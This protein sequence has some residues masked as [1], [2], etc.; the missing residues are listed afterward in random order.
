M[1]IVNPKVNTFDHEDNF[2]WNDFD[3]KYRDGIFNSYE[4]LLE[5]F[6]RDIVKVLRWISCG[7]GY[8]VKKTNL[9][10]LMFDCTDR[11]GI[12]VFPIR[13]REN[14]MKVVKGK[15]V[16]NEVELEI[17]SKKLIDIVKTEITSTEMVFRPSGNCDKTQFNCWRGF[18]AKEV[19]INNEK[20]KL[21]IDE[22]CH[23]IY[24]ILANK[25]KAVSEY[26][27][28]WLA[29]IIQTPEERPE[30][31]CVFFGEEGTGKNRLFEFY[32]KFVLG[33]HLCISLEGGLMEA[34][35]DFNSFLEGKLFVISNE[36]QIA[37]DD[38][39]ASLNKFKAR[40][41]EPTI[42]IH[43]KYIDKGPMNNF[44]NYI[45]LSNNTYVIKIGE[46]DRRY[47][48]QEVS[49]EMKGRTKSDFFKRFTKLFFNQESG[50][51]IFSYL[52]QRDDLKQWS[53][54]DNLPMTEAKKLLAELSLPNAVAFL[55]SVI[56]KENRVFKFKVGEMNDDNDEDDDDNDDNV[57][58]D[59]R[60][61]IEANELYQKYVNW[62]SINGEKSFGSKTFGSQAKS[63]LESKR[64][65][66]TKYFIK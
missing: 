47:M 59:V 20:A 43:K 27:L 51:V 35:A 32:M 19:E 38:F 50:N 33:Y 31:A 15:I 22:F 5:E 44:V 28:N 12:D 29:K 2:C 6:K 11:F 10:N 52:K 13:Y 46:N 66:G 56:D 26:I 3:A 53:G 65:N 14:S 24:F 54:S 1:N 16:E 8:Y 30:T 37:K 63:I 9:T 21:L 25:D 48:I 64:S 7:K 42:M 4:E 55:K 61:R 62:C 17:K 41:T 36:L 34:T 49:N 58:Y 23:Y 39:N 18:I 60:K 57:V 40:I 45:L